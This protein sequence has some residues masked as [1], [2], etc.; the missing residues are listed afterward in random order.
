MDI[1]QNT[2]LALFATN[3]HGLKHSEEDGTAGVTKLSDG[4]VEEETLN[5]N[6]L[7][8]QPS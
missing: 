1:I 5:Y 4:A 6:N 2:P 3:F 7:L 8:I